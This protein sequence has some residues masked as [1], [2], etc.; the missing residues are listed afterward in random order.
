M[1]IAASVGLAMMAAS[2]DAAAVNRSLAPLVV[3]L[4]ATPNV[5]PGVVRLAEREVEAIFRPIG[6]TFIWR[7]GGDAPV[8]LVVEIANEAGPNHDSQYT[9]LGWLNFANGTPIPKIHIS[10]TNAERFMEGSREVVGI[11]NLKT[12]A[13]REMLLGRL[14]GR[15]LA[16]ELG[17]YLLG[18]PEHTAK[19]LLKRSPTATEF[20]STDHG[21][22]AIDALERTQIADRLSK[23]LNLARVFP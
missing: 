13:E 9:P 5:S 10:Y 14:V 18:T 11:I 6:V 19:G 3:N 20:F 1:L 23:P 7:N 8:S 17:H 4:S 2:P 16:H 22:F 15:A 12:R 21:A